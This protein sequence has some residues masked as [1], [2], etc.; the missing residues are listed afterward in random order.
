MIE[1][2][3]EKLEA[4]LQK[5][6]NNRTIIRV[7]DYAKEQIEKSEANAQQFL[8]EK[9]SLQGAIDKMKSEAQKA[10]VG[11][12]SCLTDDEGFEIVHKYFGFSS[13]NAE[14]SADTLTPN[15]ASGV[16]V[17]LFDFL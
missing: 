12:V 14:K 9:K 5:N 4:E 2:A 10:A 6:M 17:D 1:K 7:G 8:D 11:G 15:S 3:L 16:K 13:E